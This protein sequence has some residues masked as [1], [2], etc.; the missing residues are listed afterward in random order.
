MKRIV[1][2]FIVFLSTMVTAQNTNPYTEFIV[3]KI[4]NEGFNSKKDKLVRKYAAKFVDLY[5]SGKL[6]EVFTYDPL[7][8]TFSI[9]MNRMPANLKSYEW[10]GSNEAFKRNIWTGKLTLKTERD[11]NSLFA[12][13]TIEFIEISSDI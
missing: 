5:N 3:S 7:A 11:F 2:M 12:I 10:N 8:N 1:L 4:E 13:W 6:L 9:N